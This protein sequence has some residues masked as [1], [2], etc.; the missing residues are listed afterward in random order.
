M[1]DILFARTFFIVAGMLLITAI[2]AR[3]NKAF[4][5]AAEAWISI[6]ATFALLF[7]VMFFADSFPINLILVGIF[8]ALVGW[9]IGPTIQYYGE[10][11]QR[12]KLLKSQGI[13][14]KKGETLDLEQEQRLAEELAKNPTNDQW[15]NVVFQAMFATALAVF[16]TAGIVFLTSYNFSFLGGFLFIALIIL[17]IMGILNALFFRSRIFTLIKAYFGVI[18]FTLY[19]LFDF[20]RLE[21]MAGDDSWGTAIDIAVNIY[22]DI[23]NLFLYILEILG[24]SN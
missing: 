13:N 24:D 5:T 4:E 22:L 16:A 23:I 9:Q 19:L 18:I 11:S 20:N 1:M 10:A 7:A 3:F 2:A 17:I 6:A 14:L 21:Q 8:S 15:N 12:N